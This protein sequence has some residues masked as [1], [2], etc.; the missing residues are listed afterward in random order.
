MLYSMTGYGR[1]Q[2][3]YEDGR[4][5]LGWAWEVKSVNG[6][7]FDARFRLP[8]GF[9]GLEGP[10]RAR[11]Q[12]VARRGSMT[13]GLTLTEQPQTQRVVVNEDIFAQ[14]LA[15]ARDLA[16][17]HDLA[18]PSIDRLLSVKGVV[19][20]QDAPEGDHDRAA[21]DQALLGGLDAALAAF[22]EA[23]AQEGAKIAQI[24]S[25]HLGELE[26]LTEQAARLEALRPEAIR[27]RITTQMQE[28]LGHNPPVSPERLA[29]ELAML[30]VKADVREELDRLRAHLADARSVIACGDAQGAGR[31]LDFIAQELN[32]EANTLC[33]KSADADLT[34]TGLALKL[35]VDRFREQLQNIE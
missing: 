24:L 35:H 6:K 3:R 15:T 12:S 23:R 34:R 29:Q 20:T 17:R 5:A 26:R 32:R 14:L 8:A 19:E 1:A 27:A 25:D 18:P 30:A 11:L 28:I 2:G 9:D 7:G 22:Q 4:G 31:R 10:A 21:R 33:S 13:V 16:R